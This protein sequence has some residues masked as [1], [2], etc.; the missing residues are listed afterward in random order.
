M[1]GSIWI[2]QGLEFKHLESSAAAKASALG[3]G[4]LCALPRG[5][6]QKRQ[7]G[8]SNPCGQSPMDF[9]SISLAARTHC[10]LLGN[11][12]AMH[13]RSGSDIDAMAKA[14]LAGWLVGLTSRHLLVGLQGG[15]VF[16]WSGGAWST[17]M[18]WARLCMLQDE[19]P[20]ASS[21]AGYSSVG[22][23]SECRNLQ[24]SDGPWFDSGWPD[25][26]LFGACS[27]RCIKPACIWNALIIHST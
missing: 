25:L 5:E 22:R 13:G 10:H 14:N 6:L 17:R 20:L 1:I 23:A 27:G 16:G 12:N 19:A 9:E 2:L 11:M 7:R 8:D 15:N 4:V 24:Q 3:V 21:Q 18:P 26:C